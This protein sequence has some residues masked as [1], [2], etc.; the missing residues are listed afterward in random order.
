M[1]LRL[2][3]VKRRKL[4]DTI[5]ALFASL[6]KFLWNAEAFVSLS[7]TENYLDL[8]MGLKSLDD[9]LQLASILHSSILY[10]SSSSSRVTMLFSSS[11]VEVRNS[12][13]TFKQSICNVARESTAT[14]ED[15]GFT[16]LQLSL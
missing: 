9:V 1:T 15:Q 3:F 13:K 11:F 7:T 14:N 10:W 4:G 12:S 5:L 2:G 8:S 6:L 16:C